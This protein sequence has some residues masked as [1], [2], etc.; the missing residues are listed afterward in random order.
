MVSILIFFTVQVSITESKPNDHVI[1]L[2]ITLP[3]TNCQNVQTKK[4][5]INT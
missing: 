4:K 5:T 2:S 1:S 3:K